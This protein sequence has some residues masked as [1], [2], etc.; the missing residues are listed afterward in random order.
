MQEYVYLFQAG[1]YSKIGCSVNPAQRLRTIKL[2]VC[3]ELPCPPELVLSIPVTMAR[4]AEAALHRKFSAQRVDGEWFVLDRGDIDWLAGQNDLTLTILAEELELK[5][6]RPIFVGKGE[7]TEK[8][9]FMLPCDLA[10]EF[11]AIA[12]MDY[13]S[14]SNA[15]VWI[16]QHVLPQ[17]RAEL[18]T[19]ESSVTS[20]RPVWQTSNTCD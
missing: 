17:Y 18:E 9:V 7:P 16:L 12:Q 11:R 15:L 19:R 8:M 14:N 5:D 13:R 3:P 20:P 10:S 4:R 6:Y 2:S 1:P